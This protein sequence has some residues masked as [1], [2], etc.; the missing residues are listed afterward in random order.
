[1]PAPCAPSA[2]AKSTCPW[3]FY[4]LVYGGLTDAL[5]DDSLRLGDAVARGA[6]FATAM[7]IINLTWMRQRTKRQSRR[8]PMVPDDQ[9]DRR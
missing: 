7:T 5:S 6:P 9:P 2:G 4:D 8:D 3:V 1:M